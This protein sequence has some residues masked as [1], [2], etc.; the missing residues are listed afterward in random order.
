MNGNYKWLKIFGVFAL[1]IVI[2]AGGMIVTSRLKSEM[3]QS[4]VG[5]LSNQ[6]TELRQ[7]LKAYEIPTVKYQL[8]EH[9]N[10]LTN[11]EGKSRNLEIM[12]EKTIAVMASD[13]IDIK[14]DIK[15][16]RK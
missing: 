3:T 6:I 15:E 7:E 10:R 2:S 16:L 11:V 1:G 12:F 4:N 9:K 5:R 13:L 8:E 14:E